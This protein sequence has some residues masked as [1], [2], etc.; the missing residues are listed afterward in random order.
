[1]NADGYTLALHSQLRAYCAR[2]AAQNH[3]W[4][5]VP[6]TPVDQITTGVMEERPPE[7]ASALDRMPRH[8]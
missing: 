3:E 2:G 7:P 6:A 1:M 5:R 4:V 8:P